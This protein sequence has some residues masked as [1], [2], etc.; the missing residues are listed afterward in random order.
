MSVQLG[1]FGEAPVKEPPKQY[2]LPLNAT[3]KT[4]L[5]CGFS[6]DDQGHVRFANN[7]HGLPVAIAGGEDN[8][9]FLPHACERVAKAAK[10][11]DPR[12]R[13]DW[14][15]VAKWLDQEIP[16]A[17]IV[18]AVTG[19]VRWMGDRYTGCRSL[20]LFNGSVLNLWE[21]TK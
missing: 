19:Q 8:T 4:W 9:V 12:A 7:E 15:F 6:L 5:A 21:R 11:G 17:I 16:L 14:A 13:L 1:L 3:R 2:W 20:G 10:I 18:E